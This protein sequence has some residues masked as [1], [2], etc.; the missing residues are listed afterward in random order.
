MT[1]QESAL[2]QSMFDDTSGIICAMNLPNHRGLAE[3]FLFLDDHSV[4]VEVENTP[5]SVMG[6]VK[7]FIEERQQELDGIRSSARRVAETLGI[8]FD[9]L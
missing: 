2:L 5:A 4:N 8:S 7:S 1:E 9:D 6:V 3:V